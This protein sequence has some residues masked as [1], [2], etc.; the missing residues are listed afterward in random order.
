MALQKLASV[1]LNSK[2]LFILFLIN[3][4]FTV[5]HERGALLWSI[6]NLFARIA[7]YARAWD[8][9]VN[10]APVIFSAGATSMFGPSGGSNWVES[11]ANRSAPS[12]LVCPAC[13]LTHF[14]FVDALRFLSLATVVCI[15]SAFA[16]PI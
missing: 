4:R 13:P 12:F 16:I 6:A 10:L 3:M 11:L 2:I 14:I 5:V 8:T 15:S 1:G 7:L 9:F